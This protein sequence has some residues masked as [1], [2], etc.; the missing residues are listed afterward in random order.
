MA[1]FPS[2]SPLNTVAARWSLVILESVPVIEIIGP[3]WPLSVK[4][5]S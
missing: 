5:G 2:R 1:M 3:G 4:I